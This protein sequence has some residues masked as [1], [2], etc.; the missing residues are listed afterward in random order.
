[1]NFLKSLA[2]LLSPQIAV[3]LLKSLQY[4][5]TLSLYHVHIIQY[6]QLIYQ[7]IREY[8]I[9]R[10]ILSIGEAR[11]VILVLDNLKFMCDY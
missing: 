5:D 1:M 10:Y 3:K 7:W 2:K 4:G 9:K 6:W 8:E 11:L